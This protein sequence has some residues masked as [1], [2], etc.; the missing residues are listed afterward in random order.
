MAIVI[1]TGSHSFVTISGTLIY[2][3][4]LKSLADRKSSFADEFAKMT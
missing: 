1:C 3:M 2:A 4:S